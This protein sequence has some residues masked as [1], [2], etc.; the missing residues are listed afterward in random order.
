MRV[1]AW[2][3]TLA[4][5]SIGTPCARSRVAVVWRRSWKRKS[6]ISAASSHGLKT[7]A[8]QLPASSGPVL[9]AFGNM[10]SLRPREGRARRRASS[11]SL[12]GT[13]S[14]RRKLLPA[15]AGTAAERAGGEVHVVG[16]PE[17]EHVPPAEGGVLGELDDRPVH[18]RGGR[19][20]EPALL[21]DGEVARALVLL[22]EPEAA[23]RIRDGR[24]V[25]LL[26]ATAGLVVL[27][28][29]VQGG[30]PL[31]PGGRRPA[32]LHEPRARGFSVLG[33]E[34]AD[35]LADQLGGRLPPPH[36]A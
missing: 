18:G 4:M 10:Q 16:P 36:A 3:S 31:V 12:I 21:G 9:R 30:V 27:V 2:R 14:S 15:L 34:V 20:L 1:S 25:G 28:K 29:G 17:P 5:S 13:H 22:G 26:P 11:S 19:L 7:R 8:Y 32:R 6:V 24:R 23:E 33:R 35:G